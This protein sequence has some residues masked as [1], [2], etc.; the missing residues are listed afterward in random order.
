MNIE[1]ESHSNKI[2]SIYFYQA[3]YW[4]YVEGI[5]ISVIESIPDFYSNSHELEVFDLR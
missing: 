1:Y 2:S 5:K 4:I 3:P